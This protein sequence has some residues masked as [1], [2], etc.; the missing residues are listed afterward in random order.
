VGRSRESNVCAKEDVMK[1]KQSCSCVA[2]SMGRRAA[3][4]QRG[5]KA[6]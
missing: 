4:Q 5:S 3:K 6:R 1:G 2:E